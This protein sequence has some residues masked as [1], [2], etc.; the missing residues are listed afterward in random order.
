MEGIRTYGEWDYE[1]EEAVKKLG[2]W[3]NAHAHLDRANTFAKKYLAHININPSEAAALSLRAKQDL[4]GNLH[5]GLAY[6]P[7]NL[8]ERMR[9]ELERSISLGTKEIISFIDVAPDIGLRVIEIAAKLRHEFQERLAL[10]VA[11]Y[12]IFGIGKPGRWEVFKEAAQIADLLG[13]LPARDAREGGIGS[14]EHIKKMIALGHE[15]NK[16]V[17]FQVDQD[18]DPDED[19]TERIIQAVHWLGSPKIKGISNPTV[20]AVHA[21]S[22]SCYNEERF[23]KLLSGLLKENIGVICCPSAAISMRQL[24]SKSAPIHNS[25]ARILEMME[26]GVPVRIGTDNICDVFIPSG[27]GKVES[28]IWLASNVLR[29]YDTFVWAKVGAGVM[30]NNTDRDIV[31]R[32]RR[33]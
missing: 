33:S 12:P 22:P 3:V 5:D 8:Q 11:A 28:E 10:K 23:Q 24:R 21:I 27:D 9:L 4:T 16:E 6:Q 14:D 18:N 26:A 2:G 31:Q 7:E 32:N 15:L 20:W 25:I 17:H 30:L 19:E 13:G 1:L 29:F